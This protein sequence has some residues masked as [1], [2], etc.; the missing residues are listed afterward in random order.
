[1]K[2]IVKIITF[3][4]LVLLIAILVC[5]KIVV[6]NAKERLYTSTENIP[7]NKVGLVLGTAKY[8]AD[9]RINLYYQFRLQAAIQLYKSKKI[10]FIIVSGDNGSKYYDEPTAFKEDLLKE[11]IPEEKI[12]LDYAGFRTLDSIVRVKEIF[13]QNSVT[14]I[15]QQFHNE[16]ALYLADNFGINAIG[17]NA[18]GVSRNYALKVTLREYLARVKLFIDL[19]LNTQPKFLGDPV[20]IP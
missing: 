7:K 17:F 12:F 5:N 14:V 2:R 15:S 3:I 16:R 20:I 8:L 11:G 18:Q 9:G 1:M 6:K 19:L 13:G 10:D 4:S